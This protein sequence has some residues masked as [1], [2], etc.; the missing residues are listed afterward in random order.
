MCGATFPPYGDP[1][2]SAMVMQGHKQ[3]APKSAFMVY[4]RADETYHM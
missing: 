1:C 2:Y 3:G 4:I